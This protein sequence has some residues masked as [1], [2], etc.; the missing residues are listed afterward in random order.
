MNDIEYIYSHGVC[1]YAFT[2]QHTATHRNACSRPI[3]FH[4]TAYIFAVTSGYLYS[5]RKVYVFAFILHY[6]ALHHTHCNTLQ[7]TAT[8][9]NTL[10]HTA[11]H[12]NTLQHTATHCNT[13][14]HSATHSPIQS[15][16]IRSIYAFAFTPQYTY[17]VAAI[18]RLLKII[19]LFCR[20]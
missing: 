10:Q 8:H 11:T 13:P 16:W 12:C 9:C 4:A 1:I 2:P 6:T 3:H 14:Q 19:G 20:K 18:S 15:I 7:H 5:F 17:G